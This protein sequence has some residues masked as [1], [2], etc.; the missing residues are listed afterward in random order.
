MFWELPIFPK[1]QIVVWLKAKP[2]DRRQF[3]LTQ[4][5]KLN[6]H[7]FFFAFTTRN[8]S[9]LLSFTVTLLDS[10]EKEMNFLKTKKKKI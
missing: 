9:D 3:L 1:F 8:L 6:H 7:I 4:S 2:K 5:F 10:D